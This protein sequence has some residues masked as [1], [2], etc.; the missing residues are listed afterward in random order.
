MTL[1]AFCCGIFAIG[2]FAFLAATYLTVDTKTQLDL[3]NDFRLRALWSGVALGPIALVVF[4]T[5]EQGAPEMFHGLTRWWAPLLLGWTSLFAIGALL[6][7][8]LRRFAMAR[9]AAIGQVTLVLVGWSLAQYPDLVTPDVTIDNAH[10]PDI[11]LRLLVLAL[12]AGAML[13][14]PSLAFLFHVFKGEESRM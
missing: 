13:L 12:G 10:A 2:L 5:S 3:Q 9:I 8:W 7:L 14:L 6:A 4:L 1:F 11:T